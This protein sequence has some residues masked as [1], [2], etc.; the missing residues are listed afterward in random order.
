MDLMNKIEEIRQ[1]PEHERVKYVW[2]MVAICM[3]FVFLMWIF[4]FKSLMKNEGK[5]NSGSDNIIGVEDEG[6]GELG[7]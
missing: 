6:V 7:E 2:L 3:V 1:K 4:S 5:T